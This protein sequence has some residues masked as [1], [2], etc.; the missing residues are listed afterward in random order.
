MSGALALAW[1]DPLLDL[2]FPSICP[3]CRTRSDDARH[4]PFCRACWAALP[5]LHGP[6]CAI[7]GTPYPGLGGD[8]VCDGCRHAPPPPYGFVRAVA[9]YRDGMRAAI[10]ALKYG[11]RAAVAGPLG[12]LLAEVG[13]ARLPAPPRAVA[14]AL[15]P[16]PLHP[17]R[18]SERGF[19]QA[20]LLADACAA[21]WHLPVLRRAIRRVRATPPQTALDA[22]ARRRNVAGA[23]AVVRPGEVA[24]RQLLLVDDVLT[25][26]ATAGAAAQALLDAG[27]RAVGVLVLARVEV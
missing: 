26:G 19:N 25:T 16:I 11:R 14:D 6:G 4:R 9:E 21:A 3:V 12:A 23:F 13:V 8:M 27:A 24:G 1:L 7:C 5:R 17:G 15:V 20:E 18:R 22:A 2:L 10:L